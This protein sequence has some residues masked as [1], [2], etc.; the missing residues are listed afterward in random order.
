MATP[1]GRSAEVRLTSMP[2]IPVRAICIAVLLVSRTIAIQN[3]LCDGNDPEGGTE[4][5]SCPTKPAVFCRESRACPAVVDESSPPNTWSVWTHRPYCTTTS[6]SVAEAFDVGASSATA[7]YP[8]RLHTK[9]CVFTCSYFGD[10]GISIVT[11]PRIASDVAGKIRESYNSDFP[12]P[13]TVQKLNLQPAFKVV[14]MPGKGGKGVVATRRIPRHETFMIDYASVIVDAT[15]SRSLSQAQTNQLL[16]RATEQ[17]LDPDQVLSLSGDAADTDLENAIGGIIKTNNFLHELGN[18]PQKLLFPSISRLNHECIPKTY[19]RLSNH[20]LT[21]GITALSDIHVGEEITV[22]YLEH[23][24]THAE[25]AKKTTDWGFNCTCPLCTAEAAQ[26]QESD[27]RRKQISKIGEEL[28]RALQDYNMLLARNI[29]ENG[30]RLLAE[31]GLS[32]ASGELHET[33]ARIEWILGNEGASDEHARKAADYADFASL[34]PRNRTQEIIELL[35]SE[36]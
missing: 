6:P 30:L 16:R 12:G 10:N 34:E 7:P 15:A 32:F 5:S 2:G 19:L 27:L 36:G 9:F 23:F 29:V 25:R 35:R 4:A 31:D 28:G 33:L 8:G 3:S 20:G 24:L 22:S 17:L 11:N 21:A 26:V 18:W 13:A 14:D 1:K